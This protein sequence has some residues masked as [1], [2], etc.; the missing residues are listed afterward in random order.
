MKAIS[1]GE[2]YTQLPSVKGEGS[3]SVVDSGVEHLSADDRR[4]R[5]EDLRCAG[6]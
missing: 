6:H 3:E 4:R 5:D 1:E 2:I